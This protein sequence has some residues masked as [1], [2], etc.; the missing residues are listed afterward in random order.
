MGSPEVMEGEYMFECGDK[1]Y[2]YFSAGAI[3]QGTKGRHREVC[4]RECE[5]FVVFV[6]FV[7]CL[8]IIARLFHYRKRNVNNLRLFF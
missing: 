5:F 2:E 6:Q 3:R 1:K 7:E 4:G 8:F